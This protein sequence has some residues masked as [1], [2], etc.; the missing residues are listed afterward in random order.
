MP[1]RG[2]IVCDV[3]GKEVDVQYPDARLTL[4]MEVLLAREIS[5]DSDAMKVVLK[6]I[7]TMTPGKT[8][9]YGYVTDFRQEGTSRLSSMSIKAPKIHLALQFIM[10]NLFRVADVIAV[11]IGRSIGK[12]GQFV[13]ASGST[14]VYY[15]SD[16][17][18]RLSLP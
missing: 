14:L 6:H 18:P 1:E 10:K 11:R 13:T 7:S 8:Q 15:N 17:K 3:A 9:T 16:Q 2:K 12:I 4:F 5:H